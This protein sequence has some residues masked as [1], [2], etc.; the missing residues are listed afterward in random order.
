MMKQ[1]FFSVFSLAPTVC[2]KVQESEDHKKR[3]HV[4]FGKVQSLLMCN[5][6]NNDKNETRN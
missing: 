3:F 4:L 6:F 1:L 2:V 5:N